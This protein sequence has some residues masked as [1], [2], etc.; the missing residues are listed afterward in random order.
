MPAVGDAHPRTIGPR[1]RDLRPRHR[2]F[3]KWFCQLRNASQAARKAGFKDAGTNS[4]RVTASRLLDRKDVADA[5]VE[6]TLRRLRCDLPVNLELVKQIA[7]GEA[8]KGDDMPVSYAV[9]LKALELMVGAGGAG[10]KLQVEHT[11]EVEVTVRARWEKLARMAAARGEDP[12]T[13]LANLPE[14]DR[15][16][17]MQAI[18]HEETPGALDAEFE[19]AEESA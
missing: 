19:E 17:I 6:E 1:M 3:V 15:L 4:I 7:T 8:A 9:R 18:A 11:G 14:A 16:A 5:V 12:H 2:E 13:L 10:P